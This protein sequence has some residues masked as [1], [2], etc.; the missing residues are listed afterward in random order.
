MSI[1]ISVVILLLISAFTPYIYSYCMQG[2]VV[3][4]TSKF[5]TVEKYCE[6]DDL[7]IFIGSSFKLAAPKCMDCRCEKQGLQCCGFGFAAAKLVPTEEC[8]ALNDGCNVVFVK[9]T[10]ESEL[11][12]STHLDNKGKKNKTYT[13]VFH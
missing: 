6:Y 9:K 2:P 1:H 5:G 12:L 11:C 7:K 3:T 8:V 13:K 4:K 10:N